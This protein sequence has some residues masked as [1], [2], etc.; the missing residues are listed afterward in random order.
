[1][2]PKISLA[3]AFVLMMAPPMACASNRDAANSAPITC[4]T[5]QSP[6]KIVLAQDGQDGQPSMGTTD[7]DN[8]NDNADDNDNDNDNADGNQNAENQ[9]ADNGQNGDTGQTD[10]N[11]GGN[12]QPI[13]PTV[14]G[15]DNDQSEPRQAP[16]QINP[17][18]QPVNPYQ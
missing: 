1:M 17:F 18:S 2:I 16:Q 13:P 4:R 12:Y 10:Q 14:L 5:H 6:A 15:P 11:A 8:D 3:A 9:N 7:N